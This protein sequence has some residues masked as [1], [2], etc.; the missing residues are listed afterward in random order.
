MSGHSIRVGATQ[1]LLAFNIDPGSVMQAG[2]WKSIRMPTRYGEQVMATRGGIAWAAQQ[3]G[4]DA[5]HEKQA[6]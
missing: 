2:R 4:R 5:I 6:G 1:D 3:Q